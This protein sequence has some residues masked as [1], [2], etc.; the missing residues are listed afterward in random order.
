MFISESLAEPQVDIRGTAGFGA[1]TK[2]AG[3]CKYDFFFMALLCLFSA[4][5]LLIFWFVWLDSSMHVYRFT[6][7]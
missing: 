3:K 4:A 7:N 1:Y 2:I 6:W 5:E